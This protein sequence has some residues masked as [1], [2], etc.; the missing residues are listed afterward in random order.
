[1]RK[2]GSENVCFGEKKRDN[3]CVFVCVIERDKNILR[4]RETEIERVREK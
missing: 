2:I 1:V 4:E 3:V